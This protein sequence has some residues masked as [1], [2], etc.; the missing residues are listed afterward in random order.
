M[1]VLARAARECELR[2][3][4][5]ARALVVASIV[6]VGLGTI[7]R[8][9]SAQV[10]AE[11]LK[12]N[13]LKPGW[14]GGVDG[15]FALSRGNIELLDI[16][17]AAKV[18]FQTLHPA[19]RTPGPMRWLSQRTFLTASGRFAERG[20]APFVSQAFL[21]GRWT[22]MWHPRV[23]HDLFVQFQFNE[24]LR[25]RRR[26][27]IGAGLRV[28]IVHEPLF[29]LSAGAGYMLEYETIDVAPGASDSPTALAHRMASSLTARLRLFDGGLLVQ[30]TLFFQPR[31]DAW[32]DVRILNDLEIMA[33]VTDLLALGTTI[34]IL[35][36]SAPPTSIVPLD[37]R[38]TSTVRLSF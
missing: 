1:S 33:K 29:V 34:S 18:Q 17:G 2:S 36:D 6:A 9:A 5:W 14:S 23:G 27:V 7:A 35:Y 21:F 16:G 31:F 22:A 28:E 15:S 25:L 19:D 38:M 12:P 10:N 32:D 13:V 3:V 20:G 8:A 30:N 37:L 24:F 11:T 4:R 26:S